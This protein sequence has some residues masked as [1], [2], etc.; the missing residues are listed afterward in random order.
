MALERVKNRAARQAARDQRAA[1][2]Q[3][4]RID[5]SRPDRKSPDT[6]SPKN[7]GTSGGTSGAG[8]GRTTLPQA[9]AEESGRRLT[10]RRTKLQPVLGKTQPAGGSAGAAGP[11][12]DLSKPAKPAA[13]TNGT[14]GPGGSGQPTRP[15][16]DLSKP[17]RPAA[18]KTSA[19]A[20]G[21][22]GTTG[23]KVDLSKPVKPAAGTNGTAGPGGSGQPTR[24]KVDLSKPARP[25]AGKTS[26]A[27]GGA[28][29]TTGPKV[30]LSKPVKPAAGTN[31]GAKDA[32][33]T[34]SPG[35]GSQPG[36]AVGAGQAPPSGQGAQGQPGA[37]GPKGSAG[38]E[39]WRPPPRGQRR[40]AEESMKSATGQETVITVE[41]ADNV[42]DQAPAPWEPAAITTGTS[43]LPAAAQ[44][45]PPS[46]TS[47]STSTS[48]K[49]EAPMNTPAVTTSTGRLAV[50]TPMSSGM[51]AEHATEVTIDDVLEFLEEVTKE[52][53]E[54]HDECVVLARKARDLR[55]ELDDLAAIL[56]AKHN[57]IGDL[58]SM[59]MAKLA[60]SMEVV[61]RKADEM[62]VESLIAAETA[63]TASTAM[64]DEH[65]P[66][67]QA[68]ADAGLRTP[69]ARIHNEG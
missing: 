64:A 61:A 62:Q 15:K 49:K 11:K 7:T 32:S 60:E 69:S 8:P 53:F 20:G 25:A 43:T 9:I 40:S 10:D 14:A 4:A 3:E 26:A 38:W 6:N 50:A 17:A 16:V 18:G 5:R 51:H 59:A 19:A 54:A 31:G 27:A 1:R 48:A 36:D 55:Y 37:D 56:A 39:F 44:A 23:P 45:Q 21:A 47:T 67:Q 52:S 33:A 63:E 46:D 68:T 34:T 35:D 30:D 12:V 58:T 65:K 24:P 2:R 29:G 42:G 28:A 13:G 41:R 66:I 57:I 22:A